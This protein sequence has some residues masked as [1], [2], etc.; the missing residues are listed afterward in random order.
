MTALGLSAGLCYILALAAFGGWLLSALQRTGGI[1]YGI[2]NIAL[3]GAAITLLIAASFIHG[4]RSKLDEL[5]AAVS[6]RADV[7]P[8][9]PVDAPERDGAWLVQKK[10]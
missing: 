8:S 7:Q 6:Q 1:N 3:L 5:I 2:G 4:L 9:A 10:R